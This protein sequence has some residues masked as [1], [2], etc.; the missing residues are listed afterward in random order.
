M[1]LIAIIPG[2]PENDVP[3]KIMVRPCNI[4]SS[5][6]PKLAGDQIAKAGSVIVDQI[7]LTK[8]LV[9]AQGFGRAG[10]S[11]DTA[12]KCEVVSLF[13]F[14]QA[15]LVSL[16]TGQG[17]ASQGNSRCN[18]KRR[19]TRLQSGVQPEAT[20]P[21][22]SKLKIP[23]D[24]DMKILIPVITTC[25]GRIDFKFGGDIPPGIGGKDIVPFI[26]INVNPDATKIAV[27][28]FLFDEFRIFFKVKLRGNL[29]LQIQIF[30]SLIEIAL[31]NLPK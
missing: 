31:S 13:S 22:L 3:S 2:R 18:V 1:S 17:N 24:G 23:E 30:Q 6:K 5:S 7:S 27:Q 9:F 4:N 20:D 21:L 16:I 11:N 8:I 25:P 14:H 28:T 10:K 29:I 15:G 12:P 26:K 19:V